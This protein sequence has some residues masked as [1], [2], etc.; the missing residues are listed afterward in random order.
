VGKVG[1]EVVF[2]RGILVELVA[3]IR[4]TLPAGTGEKAGLE[5][6]PCVQV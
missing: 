2:R 1:T 4:E 3:R 6:G 5:L